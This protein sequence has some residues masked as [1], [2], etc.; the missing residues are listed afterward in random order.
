VCLA[1]S[2]MKGGVP[3]S[4]AAPS[5][6]VVWMCVPAA[7]LDVAGIVSGIRTAADAAAARS[8]NIGSCVDVCACCHMHLQHG[9]WRDY[10]RC[11]CACCGMTA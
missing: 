1:L 10:I 3:L 9:M 11:V 8:C 2:G 4:R 7:A 6:A 5:A